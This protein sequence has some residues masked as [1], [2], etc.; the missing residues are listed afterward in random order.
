MSTRISLLIAA[1][2]PSIAA[3]QTKFTLPD[4]ARLSAESRAI[5]T[6]EQ[7]RSALIA[8]HDTAELRRMYA[9][10]LRGTTAN[11]SPVDLERLLVVFTR[12]DPTTAF[13]IDEIGVNSFGS[14]G[15]V[16]T[17]RLTARTPTG[18]LLYQTRF[19]HTYVWRDGR[20]QILTVQATAVP[21]GSG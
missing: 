5:L 9:A 20:W 14:A 4:T 2:I 17:A 11:G 21:T 6:F 12:D 10:D 19:T 1:C 13:A 15:A 18:N 3:A 8:A 16:F 7:R